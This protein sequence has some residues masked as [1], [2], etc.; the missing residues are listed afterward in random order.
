MNI[1]AFRGKYAELDVLQASL[2]K[3]HFCQIAV[4]YFIKIRNFLRRIFDISLYA[5]IIWI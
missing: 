1:A 5:A 3:L 4:S 2:F